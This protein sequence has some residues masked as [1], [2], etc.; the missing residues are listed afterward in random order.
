MGLRQHLSILPEY[1]EHSDGSETEI[2][3]RWWNWNWEHSS[4]RLRVIVGD[5]AAT[6][7]H[8]AGEPGPLRFG[9]GLEFGADTGQFD[10]YSPSQDH[11]TPKYHD[12]DLDIVVG[13]WGIYIAVR[14]RRK[15]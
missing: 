11:V 14:G 3:P 2:P 15:R 4:E 8:D 7:E 12:H 9:F 13:R 5:L 10:S 6:S 1:I